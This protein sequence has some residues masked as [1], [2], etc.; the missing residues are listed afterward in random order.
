MVIKSSKVSSVQV[1]LIQHQKTFTFSQWI[2][3][4]ILWKKICTNKL[5]ITSLFRDECLVQNLNFKGV[6]H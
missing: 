1:N 5:I 4:K 3:L 2:S 6:D